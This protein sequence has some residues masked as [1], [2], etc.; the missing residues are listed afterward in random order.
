MIGP[1]I[2]QSYSGGGNG[3][4]IGIDHD[5]TGGLVDA[6]HDW[7]VAAQKAEKCLPLE[8][9]PAVMESPMAITT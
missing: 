9:A 1:S 2:H 7:V 4:L 8:N 5:W 6:E 3:K